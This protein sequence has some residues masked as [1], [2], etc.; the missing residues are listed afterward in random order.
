MAQ[1]FFEP[2]R[3]TAF[4]FESES[5]EQRMLF[6][7]TIDGAF[8]IARR[9]FRNEPFWLVGDPYYKR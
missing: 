3:L 1:R 4:N 8:N 6:A 9:Y 2:D 5:G 7:Y